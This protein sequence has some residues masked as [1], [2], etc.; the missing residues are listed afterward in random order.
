MVSPLIR[1]PMAIIASNGAFE[2]EEVED[3][4]F[5]GSAAWVRSVTE[6]EERRSVAEA[7][8]AP[9]VLDALDWICEEAYMLHMFISYCNVRE[10]KR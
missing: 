9:P 8:R 7:R 1:Q 6:V 2:V 4:G 3:L 5:A 10:Q